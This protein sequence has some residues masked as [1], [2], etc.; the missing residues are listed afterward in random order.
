MIETQTSNAASNA[1]AMCRLLIFIAL[2]IYGLIKINMV[3][4]TN[5]KSEHLGTNYD[6]ALPEMSPLCFSLRI[7][8]V[9]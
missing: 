5:A 2:Y 6:T 4:L 8:R 7:G 1:R 9:L 3:P